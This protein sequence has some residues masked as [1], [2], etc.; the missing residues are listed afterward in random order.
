MCGRFVVKS[1]KV[2]LEKAFDAHFEVSEQPLFVDALPSFYLPVIKQNNRGIINL[3]KWG[4]IPSWAKDPKIGNRLINARAETI[5]EK[6]SFRNSF[7]NKRCLVLADAFYEW[8][9]N[10]KPFEIKMK[11]RSPFAFAG[12]YDVWNDAEGRPLETFSII[13]TTPN[14]MVG[15]IHGRMPVILESGQYNSFLDGRAEVKDIKKML[16]PISDE[17]IEVNEIEPLLKIPRRT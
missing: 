8:N 7:N 15:K 3:L 14:N 10:H 12:V 6:P 4:L 17:D 11:N 1:S 5:D 13:T 9:E 16:V 2:E